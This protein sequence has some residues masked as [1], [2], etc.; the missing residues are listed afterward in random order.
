MNPKIVRIDRTFT[1]TLQIETAPFKDELDCKIY[2][3][4]MY[5][6]LG[7]QSVVATVLDRDENSDFFNA[8]VTSVEK[9]KS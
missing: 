7:Y 1:E 3:E 6:N 9:I 4:E 2:L 8:Y 5:E